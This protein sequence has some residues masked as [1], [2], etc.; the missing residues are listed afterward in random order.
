MWEVQSAP[1]AS[2]LLDAMLHAGWQ[3]FAVTRDGDPPDVWL[4]RET[5][6][7]PVKRTAG[8]EDAR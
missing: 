1:A 7:R 3:P 4:R 2:L 5:P 8:Q 6:P